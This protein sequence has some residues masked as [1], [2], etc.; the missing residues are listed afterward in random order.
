MQTWLADNLALIIMLLTTAVVVLAYVWWR[1]RQR[2]YAI[3]G[4]LFLVLIGLVCL[5]PLFLGESDKQ[6]IER[7]L[8]EMAASV[9]TRNLDRIF[10]HISSD[11]QYRSQ[12]KAAF[13]KKAEEAIRQRN[14]EE[15]VIW[16]VKLVE[17][18]RPKRLA[19]VAFSVKGRGNWSGGQEYYRCVTDFRLDPDEQWRMK[20]LA[21]YN[22]FVETDREI[23]IPGF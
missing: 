8:Q 11:F 6:Q 20:T 13:R 18:S 16:D 15:V 10:S 17:L 21:I 7:K 1:P 5:L 3:G 9:K 14:V 4:G 23:P 2:A 19:K 12:D 22:P